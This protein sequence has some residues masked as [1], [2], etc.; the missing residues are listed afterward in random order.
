M[1]PHSPNAGPG[2]IGWIQPGMSPYNSSARLTATP[3]AHFIQETLAEPFGW[4][5]APR[6]AWRARRWRPGLGKLWALS[7]KEGRLQSRTDRNPR[8]MSGEVC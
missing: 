1:P 4:A 7:A 3:Y 6:E 8:D 2:K 5:S